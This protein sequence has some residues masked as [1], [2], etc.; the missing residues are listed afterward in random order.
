MMSLSDSQ[1]IELLNPSPEKCISGDIPELLW[2]ALASCAD[3]GGGACVSLELESFEY[4]PVIRDESQVGPCI[5][6]LWSADDTAAVGHAAMPLDQG[7]I[8]HEMLF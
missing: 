1:S 5:V 2:T 6:T 4:Q 7:L 3:T 8:G